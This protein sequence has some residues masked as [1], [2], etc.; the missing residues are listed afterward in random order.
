MVPLA[1]PTRKPRRS[2]SGTRNR[3]PCRSEVYEFAAPADALLDWLGSARSN[4]SGLE[5]VGSCNRGPDPDT[6]CGNAA[7][8]TACDR[9]TGR[10][11]PQGSGGAGEPR[12]YCR[13]DG[14]RTCLRLRCVSAGNM[15]EG[16]K[17]FDGV[18][19]P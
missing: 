9:L 12:G 5:E 3:T 8:G 2:T 7:S 13:T 11:E 4:C 15:T 18:C 19:V 14:S 16:L 1:C 17:T 6:L 10:C